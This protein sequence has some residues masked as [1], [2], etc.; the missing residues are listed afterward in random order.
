MKNRNL[1]HIG[2]LL[3]YALLSVALTYP[4]ITQIGSALPGPPGDNWQYLWNLWWMREVVSTPGN[5]L[6]HTDFLYYPTGVSL[7]FDTLTIFDAFI[8]LPLQLI[9][10]AFVAYNVAILAAFSLSGWGAYLLSRY[11]IEEF[12]GENLAEK[13]GTQGIWLAAFVAGFIFTYS[14]YH[15]AHLLGHLNLVAMQWLPFYVLSSLRSV[16]RRQ[17]RYVPVAGVF[18]ALTALADWYYVMYLLIFTFILLLYRAFAAS[19]RLRTLCGDLALIGP[20]VVLSA[21]LVSPLLVPM[22]REALTTN[23]AVQPPSQTVNQSPDLLAFLAPSPF[24]PLWGQFVKQ[25]T[26]IYGGSILEKVV[27]MGYVPLALA[28]IGIRRRWSQTKFWA[29]VASVFFVLSLGPLL[30]FAGSTTFTAFKVNIPLPYILFYYL[31]F[32]KDS[33][34]VSRFDVIVMLAVGVMAA[35]GLVVLMQ[36]L[37]MRHQSVIRRFRVAI[38]ILALLVIGFEFLAV[39]Y[40][41]SSPDVSPIYYQIAQEKGDF[42]VFD[43]PFSFL[44]SRYLL[45]QTVHGKKIIGGY[46]SRGQ[47]YPFI[48]NTPAVQQLVSLELNPDINSIDLGSMGQNVL[49]YYGIGYVIVHKGPEKPEKVAKDKEIAAQIFGRPPDYEDA[50]VIA[51]KVAGK[52]RALFAN[53]GTGWYSKELA[54]G[55]YARWMA[56]K[57]SLEIVSSTNGSATV[58]FRACSFQKERRIQVFAGNELVGEFTVQPGDPQDFTTDQFHVDRGST[59]LRIQAVQPPESPKTLGQG[60]DVRPLSVQVSSVE[61]SD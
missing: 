38:P 8:T 58:R 37:A 47:P 30:H 39:P 22:L 27:N 49:D 34:S 11:L 35:W 13:V 48:E 57:A 10:N 3:A 19:S 9:F 44:Q 26:S 15:F 56:S 28:V 2:A 4:V 53:M 60:N 61:V 52:G 41:T 32:V 43:L 18:L 59:T 1:Q 7:Y 6:F 29:L 54:K 50:Q 14:P 33:R 25:W 45:Y 5:T 24:H 23:S 55:E 17:W 21:L 36:H 20:A 40:A 42:A 46:I 51:Y 16:Y 12:G 31:P